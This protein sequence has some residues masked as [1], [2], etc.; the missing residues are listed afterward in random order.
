[1]TLAAAAKPDIKTAF[2]KF[3]LPNV[4]SHEMALRP[5]P[6]RMPAYR[7]ALAKLQRNEVAG[8]NLSAPS[9]SRCA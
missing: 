9:V 4:P 2:D 5:S 6:M 1:M 8:L 7:S 3:S